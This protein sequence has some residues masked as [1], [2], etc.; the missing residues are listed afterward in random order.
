MVK[1]SSNNQKQS[2]RSPPLSGANRNHDSSERDQKAYFDY[3]LNWT[4]LE[5]LRRMDLKIPLKGMKVLDLGCGHGAL[6]IKLAELG[7]GQVVG[8]DLNQDRVEF[9]ERNLAS[10]F[11]QFRDRVHFVCQDAGD[12]TPDEQFD[13]IVSKDTFEHVNDLPGLVEQLHRLLKPGGHLA[14]G[15]SPL[16][17]S[18]FGD[19]GRF[20]MGLPWAH[21]VLPESLLVRLR[22]LRSERKIT[23]SADLNLNRLTPAEF[24]RIFDCAAKWR[25]IEIAYNRGSKRLLPFFNLVRRLP[26]MEKFFTISI[27]AV[28][29]KL[30]GEQS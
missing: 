21:A 25:K 17:Y 26:L 2:P 3:E 22:N 9:S 10:E 19:H 5:W 7:A 28:A 20:F 11:P 16:Y 30:P 18:P 12:L 13:L 4:N 27:Y 6:S 23:S 8:L 29:Q 14:S 15:F 1:F 24:R